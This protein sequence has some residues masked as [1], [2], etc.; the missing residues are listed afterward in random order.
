MNVAIK[1]YG[2]TVKDEGLVNAIHPV[3]S[4]LVFSGSF[5][6]SCL[7]TENEKF[8]VFKVLAIYLA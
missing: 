3:H 6:E 1:K 7:F 2:F 4:F 8:P 5:F